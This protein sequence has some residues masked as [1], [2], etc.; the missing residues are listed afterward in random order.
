MYTAVKQVLAPP[1][2]CLISA[3]VHGFNSVLKHTWH[4]KQVWIK[5]TAIIWSTGIIN[6]G[7]IC[8]ETIRFTIGSD[9]YQSAHSQED[10]ATKCFQSACTNILRMKLTVIVGN[11]SK[12]PKLV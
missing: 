5:H 12:R 3:G 1:C 2:Y 9:G 6:M 8:E 11:S 4:T 10:E 7:H